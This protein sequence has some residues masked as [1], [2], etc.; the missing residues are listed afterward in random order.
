MV[1]RTNLPE[2]L[3]G[4]PFAKGH[5]PRRTLTSAG[6]PAEAFKAEMRTLASHEDVLAAVRAVLADHT[7]PHFIAAFKYMA[8]RG[9]GKPQVHIDV[10]SEGASITE[11]LHAARLRAAN[12]DAGPA[13]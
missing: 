2:T 9:Y 12:R 10:T 5:D 8:D 7:H 1:S 4:R 3:R 6:R 13:S 11:I